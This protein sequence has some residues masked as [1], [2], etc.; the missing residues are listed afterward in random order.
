MKAYEQVMKDGHQNLKVT[1]SG[2]VVNK[3]FLI[4][5]QPLIF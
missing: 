5:M 1:N 4:Y 3:E 2:V